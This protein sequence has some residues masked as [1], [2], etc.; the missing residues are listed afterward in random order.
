[1]LTIRLLTR[2]A[3][4][5]QQAW[6]RLLPGPAPASGLLGSWQ[7]QRRRLESAERLLV[8]ARRRGLLLAQ[9]RLRG[10]WLRHL[11]RLLTLGQDLTAQLG[12]T[13]PPVPSPR[14][15]LAE[16]RQLQ[17]EFGSLSVDWRH[18]ALAVTTQSITLQGLALGPFQIAL[19][20][21]RL[22][23]GSDSSCFE[24]LAL[25]AN[26]S[27]A[28][29]RVIHPHVRNGHL[30]AGDANT[31]MCKALAEGRL[32]DAF[33]LVHGVLAHY[34]PGSAHVRLEEW[35]GAQCH[36]C[37]DSLAEDDAYSCEAC[38]ESYCPECIGSCEHCRRTRCSGCLERCDCCEG[39]C[40]SRCLRSLPESGRSLCPVCWRTCP[41]CGSPFAS[42][43]APGENNCCPLVA[44]P[45]P[46]TP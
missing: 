17:A 14:A 46:N 31:P 43:E 33:W 26:P 28:D 44:P 2:L 25:E 15:F 7:E 32:A 10:D 4:R 21:D 19:H 23:S 39:H 22:V 40:C 18:H 37:G 30:C 8:S 1:M 5:L 16:L 45:P 24:V 3:A 38:Q 34:N 29:D 11:R 36:D 35:S 9:E 6:T 20:W 27:A 13:T 41:A 12:A 42:D